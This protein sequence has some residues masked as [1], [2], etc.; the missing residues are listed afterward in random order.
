MELPKNIHFVLRKI[1][2]S[3]SILLVDFTF[4]YL[5]LLDFF[6]VLLRYSQPDSLNFWDLASSQ[7]CQPHNAKR[8]RKYVCVSYHD[9]DNGCK[10]F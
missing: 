1:E 4:I 9:S 2:T 5:N 6:I 10:D 3:N 8:N 7:T